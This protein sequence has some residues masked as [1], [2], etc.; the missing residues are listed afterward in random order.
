MT[1]PKA[2]TEP[3]AKTQQDTLKH[4]VKIGDLD[5]VKS[6]I[7]GNEVFDN[8]KYEYVLREAI[9]NGHLNIVKYIID[10][11]GF[12][13]TFISVF[14]KRHIV[15][16]AQ[17]GHLE[18]IK[19]IIEHWPKEYHTI[20]IINEATAVASEKGYLEIVMFLVNELGA[21]VQPKGEM[22]TYTYDPLAL[23]YSIDK[24]HLEIV[25][26][27][28]TKIPINDNIL[29]N[30][31]YRA[32]KHLHFDIVRYLVEEVGAISIIHGPFEHFAENE[33]ALHH[34]TWCS[35][36][37]LIKY[38]I[39]KH[40]DAVSA[41][42]DDKLIIRAVRTH[43]MDIIRY[44]LEPAPEGINIGFNN[45]DSI[46]YCITHYDYEDI[47][48][49]FIG[50]GITYNEVFI[51]AARHGNNTLL[52][53]YIKDNLITINYINPLDIALQKASEHG[54]WQT[55]KNLIKWG[56]NVDTDNNY[57][58]KVAAGNGHLP[59]VKVLCAAGANIHVDNDVLLR[60][61]YSRKYVKKNKVIEYLKSL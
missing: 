24:G 41:N 40:S 27:L 37:E 9:I 21:N 1:E 59:I 48:N 6:I 39:S 25:K 52:Q 28:L 15:I 44:Y 3:E 8:Y 29:K 35:S 26:F 43:R 46:L 45:N 18:I 20:N 19:Y 16:A 51:M 49:Y 60:A 54:F 33:W 13:K 11:S 31:L 30:T 10:K 2:K 58:L 36:L 17:N 4:G 23:I 42:V 22:S 7:E 55:V 32:I 57:A 53:R 12:V 5:I 14:E 56:A 38:F 47:I 34:A 50:K 61:V